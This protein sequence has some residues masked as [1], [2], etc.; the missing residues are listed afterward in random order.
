VACPTANIIGAYR[1]FVLNGDQGVNAGASNGT[2]ISYWADNVLNA[3]GQPV[4]IA[5]QAFYANANN[6]NLSASEFIVVSKGYTC[7]PASGGN[8]S[9]IAIPGVI[10]DFK[11]PLADNVLPT[12][13]G[14]FRIPSCQSSINGVPLQLDTT[15]L[16][17]RV[18][19]DPDSGQPDRVVGTRLIKDDTNITVPGG[20]KVFIPGTGWTNTPFSFEPTFS[21]FGGSTAN[22][23]TPGHI[24]FYDFVRNQ[25][26][27]SANI[28]GA[29]TDLR[30]I[31]ACSAIGPK[32]VMQLY[33]LGPIDHRSVDPM[34]NYSFEEC[35]DDTSGE[36]PADRCNIQVNNRTTNQ[37]ELG[38]QLIFEP[39]K[40]N[41][42]KLL[43]NLQSL[44][45]GA[46]DYEIVVKSRYIRSWTGST[47]PTGPYTI[48]FRVN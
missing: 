22:P 4:K 7:V 15:T 19:I 1:Y 21:Y 27:C 5:P 20:R 11:N 12:G 2:S 24:V 48:L 33:F 6:A 39:P 37:P 17:T 47:G 31:P 8:F 36:L 30:S 25:I 16:V 3:Q 35:T 41:Q 9:G 45:S 29:T 13:T 46:Q 10:Q 43:P 38:Y 14:G 23:A 32:T 34:N 18:I 44:P 26:I 28:T 42:I 40:S